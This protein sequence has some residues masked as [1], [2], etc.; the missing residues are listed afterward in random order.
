MKKILAILL[1]AV[2]AFAF[3]ACGETEFK[4]TKSEGT[5][6][7]AEYDAAALDSEVVIEAY[8]Q[9]KQGWWEKDGVGVATIYTQDTEGAYFIYNMPISQEDYNKLVKGTKIK[10]TGYKSAWAE[11][12]EITDA[13]YE[14]IEGVTYIAPAF[15]ATALLGTEDLIKHQ[16]KFASFKGLTIAA[17]EYQNGAPAANSDIYVKFTLGEGTYDFCVESY[18]TGPDTDV[19]KAFETLKVG[20]IVDVEGF[21]YWY[22]GVNTHITSISAVK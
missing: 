8:V 16:N 13:T 18:L 20:D 14:I 19:Y 10:V 12:V 9:A 1:V 7:Y 3:V 6:T 22:N 17:V 11:E 4:D 5:M 2:L 21:I 15:D